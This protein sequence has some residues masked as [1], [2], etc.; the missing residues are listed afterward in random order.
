MPKK[1]PRKKSKSSYQS[2]IAKLKKEKEKALKQRKELLERKRELEEL[3]EYKREIAELKGIGTK[4]RVAAQVGKKLG[5]DAGRV[6]LKGL[7]MAGKFAKN[8]IEAEQREQ[9]RERAASRPKPKSK[10]RKKRK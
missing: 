8:I 10:P 5:K 9:A 3:R 1:K 7:K 4:R 2:E 6:G